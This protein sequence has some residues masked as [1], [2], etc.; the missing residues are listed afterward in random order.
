[1]GLTRRRVALLLGALLAAWVIVLF[2]RQVGEASEAT[3]Q[4]DAMRASNVTLQT[5]V[6]AAQRE[7]HQ[8]QQPRLHRAAGARVPPRD[9]A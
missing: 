4:A 3:T 2:A 7:L 8:I 9:A 6:V 5:Q 1:M